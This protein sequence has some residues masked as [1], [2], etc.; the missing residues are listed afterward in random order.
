MTAIVVGVD[1]DR[2]VGES[3][4]SLM[5]SA[6]Y[7]ELLFWSAEEFLQS[8][9]L[10][11]AS[12]LI[13]DLKMSGMDGIELQRSVRVERPDLPVIIISAHCDDD[14]RRRALAGGAVDFLCKPL[15]PEHLLTTVGRALKGL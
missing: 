5:A 7:V 12:C 14:V 10:M 2:R 1:D 15:D 13:A 8:G 9:T 3:I 4:E 6:G 11:V